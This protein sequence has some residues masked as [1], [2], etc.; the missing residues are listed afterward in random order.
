[1]SYRE[2]FEIWK[3][4]RLRYWLEKD[5]KVALT[6]SRIDD[7]NYDEWYDWTILNG[8]N[9]NCSVVIP[10]QGSSGWVKDNVWTA[11]S[12]LLVYCC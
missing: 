4:D 12:K 1:M 7:Y 10:V 5:T 3:I 2:I 6:I 9:E 8:I 11:E